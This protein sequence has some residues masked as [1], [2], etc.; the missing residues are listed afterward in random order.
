M[1]QNTN[2]LNKVLENLTHE[3]LLS[4]AK[5]IIHF[6]NKKNVPDGILSKKLMPLYMQLE[7]KD[8]PMEGQVLYDGR[9]MSH[10]ITCL[11]NLIEGLNTLILMDYVNLKSKNI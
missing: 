11:Q 8:P 4:C 6:R 1:S 3:E 10:Y 2:T 5:E 7:K 9:D